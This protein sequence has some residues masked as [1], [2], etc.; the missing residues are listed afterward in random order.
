[1]TNASV[2]YFSL[3]SELDS[4]VSVTEANSAAN[5]TE[6]NSAANVTETNS[7]VNVTETHSAA[8]ES[9]RYLMYIDHVAEIVCDMGYYLVVDNENTNKINVTCEDPLEPVRFVFRSR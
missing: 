8:N 3:D 2:S 7:A 5:V 9:K 1:M 6:A 4:A